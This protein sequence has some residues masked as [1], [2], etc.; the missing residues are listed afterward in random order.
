MILTRV[1]AIVVVRL[2]C[3]PE[4]G[5]VPLFRNSQHPIASGR[6][7]GS[8][9]GDGGHRQFPRIVTTA[10][11]PMRNRS[12][13]GFCTRNRH[14]IS[15]GQMH[16]ASGFAAAGRPVQRPITSAIWV[17]PKPIALQ[18]AREV[19]VGLEY[20]KHLPAYLARSLHGLHGKL[21]GP[22]K[23]RASMRGTFA[24]RCGHKRFENVR[25]VTVTRTVQDAEV[26]T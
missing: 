5:E 18:Y 19:H 20:I 7:D 25:L 6:D 9:V 11:S 8:T 4:Y 10:D 12:G 26:A 23:V 3:L 15:R 21:N 13:V 17:T 24:G 14:R 22:P 2:C 16:P 1:A